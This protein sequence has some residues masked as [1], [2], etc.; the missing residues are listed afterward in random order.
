MINYPDFPLFP[1]GAV[2][3]RKSNPPREDWER[4][5]QVAEED[6]LN[7][8]RYWLMWGSIEIEPG[9]FDFAD[10]DR[11][12]DLAAKHG[13]K[14][15]ISECTHSAP[16]WAFRQYIHARYQRQDGSRVGSQ[17]RNSSVT[18]G[19][20][21]LCL[22]NEDYRLLAEKWL[23]T[24]AAHYKDH[25]A[26]GGYDIWN[27]TNAISSGGICYCPATLEKFRQWLREK[28]GSLKNL[29][30]AWHRYS[31]ADWQDVNPPLR[32][33]PYPDSLDWQRF[34]ID[35]VFRLYK[36]RIDTIRSVDT[37][38]LLTAHGVH[39]MTLT[40]MGSGCDDA[41]RGAE[42]VQ[43]YGYGGGGY[44]P[45][46]EAWE[47]W[48]C[49]DLTRCAADGKPI[50]MAEA[51]S[52]PTWRP[53][54]DMAPWMGKP[55]TKRKRDDGRIPTD[56]DI[57][58]WNLS[59]FG[60]GVRGHYCNR[61]RPLLDGS[62]FGTAG[63]YAMD[64]SRT[65][66]SAMWSKIARWANNPELA[67]MWEALPVRGDLAIL[68]V[69]DSQLFCY[70]FYNNSEYYGKAAE[71]AYQAFFNNNIQADFAKLE[72]IDLYQTIYLPYPVLLPRSV[73]HKLM[74]WVK[75]G[76]TLISEG[77]PGYFDETGRAGT[78][79]PNQ[80]LD[81]LFG[82]K[83]EYV[84]F[85]PDLAEDEMVQFN[86]NQK[87]GGGAYMQTYTLQGGR[88]VGYYADGRIAAVENTFEKGKTLLVGTGIGWGYAHAPGVGNKAFFA[89]LLDWAGVEQ[90]VRCSDPLVTARLHQGKAGLYLW[91]TN[92]VKEERVV[93]LSISTAW[94]SFKSAQVIWGG[95]APLVQGTKIE[96]RVA[97]RDGVVA[98]LE[99]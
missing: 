48:I 7:T 34:Q 50:W 56:Q 35:N 47:G 66:K 9:V 80:G 65:P 83:E 36:W 45:A 15:I 59:A 98:Y 77:C 32:P 14:V 39:S 95:S 42:P 99:K 52:G 21:G 76:G 57:R 18:G 75:N 38:C 60:G 19:F 28:Y 85:L 86:N 29:N 41:W 3:F 62:L 23:K 49:A 1:Y 97:G 54:S 33:G 67:L 31:M 64:G 51:P 20:P 55:K 5:Y 94:G 4:D 81:V 37:K 11:N 93:Q 16:D 74:E 58:V 87:A 10:Y 12:F 30:E 24:L 6:G 26:M 61:W 63:A 2:Y 88:A 44:G 13:F 82:A 70:C 17:M 8:F 90:H 71:G 73:S 53:P 43:V 89:S 91:V 68:V 40:R 46:D 79:Q 22:D 27:E 72:Q 78:V 69:P 25:P 92:P 84:E 96:V